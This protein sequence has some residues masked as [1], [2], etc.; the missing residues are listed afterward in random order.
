MGLLDLLTSRTALDT[1][2]EALAAAEAA[3]RKALDAYGDNPSDGF[4]KAV[5][6]AA[7]AVTKATA[8]HAAAQRRAAA[9]EAAAAAKQRALDV[10]RLE[11]LRATANGLRAAIAPEVAVLVTAERTAT[12]AI[13]RAREKLAE[14]VEAYR[15]AQA[16]AERLGIEVELDG[17]G[18]EGAVRGEI[19]RAIGSACVAQDRA[20]S[21]VHLWLT[22]ERP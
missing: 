13:E 22:A 17:L 5:E 19:A 21:V 11:Q 6:T 9:D 18:Y 2:R 20:G 12:E 15:A 7:T 4:W 1:A 3:H 8:V 10:A 14:Q 16:L